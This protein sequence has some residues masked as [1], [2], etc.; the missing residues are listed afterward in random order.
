[1]KMYQKVLTALATIAIL[2]SAIY[3]WI[4]RTHL[5]AQRP[6]DLVIEWYEG[7]GMN[8]EGS[9]AT[10]REGK[11]TREFT[12]WVDGKIVKSTVNFTPTDADLDALY[13]TLRSNAFDTIQETDAMIYDGGNDS[14]RISWGDNDVN[15]WGLKVN[16]WDRTRFDRVYE[17]IQSYLNTHA[18]LTTM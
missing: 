6:S 9:N 10:M 4:H 5:P 18:V 13:A 15:I 7:G 11:G 1:M 14:V 3:A 8:P 16:N 12:S 2:G 17:A